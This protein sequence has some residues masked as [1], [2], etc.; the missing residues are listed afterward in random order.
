MPPDERQVLAA[1]ANVLD[2]DR[3]RFRAV[4]DGQIEARHAI[5]DAAGMLLKMR[6]GFFFLFSFV[7]F[8]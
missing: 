4:A 7:H 1:V 6:L 5:Y 2:R 8:D 3:D